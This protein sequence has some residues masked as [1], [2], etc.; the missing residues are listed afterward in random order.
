MAMILFR[1]MFLISLDEIVLR[2]KTVSSA[3]IFQM[4][5]GARGNV[6]I[7]LANAWRPLSTQDNAV[8][9]LPTIF[10]RP[11]TRCLPSVMKN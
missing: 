3:G 2:A 9:E 8:A 1:G 7:R 11:V 4:P 6:L 5:A 10:S